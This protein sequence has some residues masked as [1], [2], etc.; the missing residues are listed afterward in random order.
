VQRYTDAVSARTAK[1]FQFDW[2]GRNE[3]SQKSLTRALR[4]A[5]PEGK[6]HERVATFVEKLNAKIKEFEAAAAAA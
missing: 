6:A 2:R 4:C 1:G 3:G 5:R